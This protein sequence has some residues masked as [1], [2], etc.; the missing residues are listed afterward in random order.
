MTQWSATRLAANPV[1]LVVAAL[2]LG[3]ALFTAWFVVTLVVPGCVASV[4][5]ASARQ[6]EADLICLECA[7]RSTRS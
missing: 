1:S 2:L 7:P 6:A 3:V 4:G 5:D